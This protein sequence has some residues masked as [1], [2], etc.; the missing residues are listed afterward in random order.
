MYALVDLMTATEKKKVQKMDEWL[1]P[2][3]IPIEMSLL[4]IRFPATKAKE[5]RDKVHT[6]AAHKGY[7]KSLS[8]Y[9]DAKT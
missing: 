8:C 7:I 3:I 6:C 2:N 9:I 4:E 1:Q 5:Q